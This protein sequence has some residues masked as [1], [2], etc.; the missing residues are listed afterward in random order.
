M[1]D[2][3]QQ[4]TGGNIVNHHLVAIACRGLLLGAALLG[5]AGSASAATM[6]Y[7]LTGT[8]TGNL[9]SAPLVARPFVIDMETSFTAL[10]GGGPSSYAITFYGSPASSTT[11]TLD[12]IGT[13]LFTENT[14]I[15]LSAASPGSPSILWFSDTT[16]GVEPLAALLR[17]YDLTGHTVRDAFT[18][19]NPL[20]ALCGQTAAT[21]TTTLG[22]LTFDQCGG[23]IL[24]FT[25][26]TVPLPAAAWLFGAALGLLGSA[27]RRRGK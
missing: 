23:Q 20:G 18:A 4:R 7:T 5:S 21:L 13:A 11:I 16:A 14:E 26:T 10:W 24:S 19:A 2:C 25:S 17:S 27:R 9:A 22:A 6:H 8:I 15:F 12:G 1:K 3:A